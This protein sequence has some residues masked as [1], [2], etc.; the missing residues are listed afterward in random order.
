MK[1]NT[2]EIFDLKIHPWTMRASIKYI[3]QNIINHNINMK[4]IVVN[5]AKLVYSQNDRKLRQA[6]N[7]SDLVNIDGLPIVLVLRL[8]GYDVPER[9]AGID[10]F[11]NL[12]DLSGRKDYRPYFLGA[13]DE[14]VEK[15][16]DVFTDQYPGLDVAGYR[17]GYF[18]KDQEEN[19]AQEI[20]EEEINPNFP[21]I[22]DINQ[23]KVEVSQS[24]TNSRII[25]SL[26][27][28]KN[29]LDQINLKV[30]QFQTPVISCPV[31]TLPE[32]N[33]QEINSNNNTNQTANLNTNQK[34]TSANL[35]RSL[36]YQD[37]CD[38]EEKLK[39]STQINVLTDKDYLIYFEVS[40]N[41]DEQITRLDN[42]LKTELKGQEENLEYIDLRFG[43]RI[44]FK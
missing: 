16:V 23:F 8:F 3:D 34:P 30:T 44:Y 38:E 7:N 17:N 15:T 4:Q 37:D 20:K 11:M 14:V 36:V 10:L 35:N 32:E 22:N 28:L 19:I 24:V 43:P 18:S 13:T 21:L 6:I 40:K 25:S 31:I 1:N 12:V 5:V 41:L 42:I 2:I 27:S 33:N 39:Q 9:V 26:D 29:K